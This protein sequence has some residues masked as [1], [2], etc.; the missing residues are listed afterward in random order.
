MNACEM[1]KLAKLVAKETV[2][3]TFLTLGLNVSTPE[4]ILSVQNQFATLRNIHYGMRQARNVLIAGVL[5]AVSFWR[6]W[7]VL[8]VFA[9]VNAR[10]NVR[11]NAHVCAPRS[12][13]ACTS[14]TNVK[15]KSHVSESAAMAFALLIARQ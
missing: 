10:V 8:C 2:S 12:E 4:A 5:G 13:A 1:E 6:E 14:Q 7:S 11:V 15:D 9:F 3:E